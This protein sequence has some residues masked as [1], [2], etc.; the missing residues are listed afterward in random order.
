MLNFTPSERLATLLTNISW[1]PAIYPA[2]LVVLQLQKWIKQ[3]LPP[4]PPIPV[5]SK[6]LN[7]LT[8]C[9]SP[10]MAQRV[11][12][13]TVCRTPRLFLA[14]VAGDVTAY[15]IHPQREKTIPVCGV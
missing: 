14:N 2:L 1:S 7:W 10:P 3:F 13:Y 12:S 11:L 4:G 6:H 5:F 8:G 9:L 15:K